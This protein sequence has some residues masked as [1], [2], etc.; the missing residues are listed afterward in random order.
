MFHKS[1]LMTFPKIAHSTLSI[2][3]A[4]AQLSVARGARMTALMWPLWRNKDGTGTAG[5]I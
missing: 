4:K 5:R 2:Y 3:Y 1:G